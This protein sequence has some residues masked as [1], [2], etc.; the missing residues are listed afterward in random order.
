MDIL[1]H[2]TVYVETEDIVMYSV[3]FLITEG[4]PPL[5]QCGSEWSLL[6]VWQREAETHSMLMCFEF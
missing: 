2:K 4:S 3:F 5:Q 1:K 6:V